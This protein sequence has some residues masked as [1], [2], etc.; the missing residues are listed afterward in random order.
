ME[1][2]SKY[3]TLVAVEKLECGELRVTI[4]IDKD[5]KNLINIGGSL[6]DIK[7]ETLGIFY[8]STAL[9]KEVQFQINETKEEYLGIIHNAVKKIIEELQTL[10]L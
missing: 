5:T 9:H 7:Q 2:I 10:D 8:Y 3:L 1:I 4:N 6:V